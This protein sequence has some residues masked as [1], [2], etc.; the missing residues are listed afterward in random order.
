MCMCM[1]LLTERPLITQAMGLAG[2]GVAVALEM[3]KDT[4]N[5]I[6]HYHS[7]VGDRDGTCFIIVSLQE[8]VK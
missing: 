3:I 5:V 6:S 1:R 2:F 8:R 7:T 4:A